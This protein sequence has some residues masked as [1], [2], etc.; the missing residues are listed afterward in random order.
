MHG[1]RLSPLPHF[2]AIDALGGETMG[3]TWSV[4]LAAGGRA[5][6]ALHD[7]VQACLDRVVAQMSTWEPDSDLCRFN[8]APPGWHAVPEDCFA[9]VAC[10]LD[11]ARAS[12]GAFDPTVGPAVDA[13]GF[14]PH[15]DPGTAP[16]DELIAAAQAHVGWQRL[17]LRA[18][19]REMHQPGG[20]ALDLSAIAKGYAV[21][22]VVAH[23]RGLGFD[24]ALVEV[25]GELAGFGRKPD[26]GAWRV[27]VETD[28]ERDDAEPVVLRLEDCAV[29]TSGDRWH[30]RR[31]GADEVAHTLDP[32]TGRPLAA[33]PLAV[34]VIDAQAMRADA[35]ATALSVLGGDDGFRLASERGMA[36]RLVLPGPHG[37]EVRETAAFS[38]HVDA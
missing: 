24:G 31:H 14:G 18:D 28:P 34:T 12:A 26:G 2:A 3:T 23:L 13:W 15:A 10:A 17:A 25:G 6:H 30:R 38:R 33:A 27:L 7:G 35:W 5:L 19:S 37:S 22:L 16:T 32:R 9:V 21:D 11:I 36:A 1:I 29:A 20:I 8:R 4:K